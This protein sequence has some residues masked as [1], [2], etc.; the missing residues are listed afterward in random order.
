MAYLDEIIDK[1]EFSEGWGVVDRTQQ[2]S[3]RAARSA[4][5]AMVMATLILAFFNSERLVSWARE[6]PAGDVSATVY[7]MAVVW[8]AR[9][10][11][12]GFD[13]PRNTIH[14]R[15]E[16]MRAARWEDVEREFNEFRDSIAPT[17]RRRRVLAMPVEDDMP[18]LRGQL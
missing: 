2:N 10:Q 4:L 7:E 3:Q 18:P 13:I 6:L 8:N 17:A 5:C 9:M 12:H 14:T 16:T 11:V 15:L 1:P